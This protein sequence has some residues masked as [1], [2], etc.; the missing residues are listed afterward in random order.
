MEK[1]SEL[2]NAIGSLAKQLKTARNAE[3]FYSNLL[4]DVSDKLKKEAINAW[5]E[6]LLKEYEENKKARTKLEKI[7]KKLQQ[8]VF[9]DI[10]NQII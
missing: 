9:G 8:K 5:D 1:K 7:L 2:K 10:K 6:L 4:E 3:E